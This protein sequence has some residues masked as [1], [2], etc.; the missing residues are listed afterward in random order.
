MPKFKAR[1][2]ELFEHGIAGEL[3][4]VVT[5]RAPERPHF[6]KVRRPISD[7]F[8]Q[9]R[10]EE[11]ILADF[12]IERFDQAIDKRCVDSDFFGCCALFSPFSLR[13][14]AGAGIGR[15]RTPSLHPGR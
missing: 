14:E 13:E 9:D 10:A 8:G 2:S 5:H 6:G 4:A 1:D 7:A 15:M 12:A 3:V 11:V